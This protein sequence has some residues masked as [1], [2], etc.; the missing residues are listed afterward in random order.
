MTER[1]A[2]PPAI[3]PGF[4]APG[5]AISPITLLHEV[6]WGEMDALQHVNNTVYIKWFEDVRF[7]WFERVGFSACLARDNQFPILA[8]TNIN[9]LSPVTFPDH[10]YVSTRAVRI[11]RSSLDLDCRAW[12]CS[13]QRLCAE[14]TATIVMF[15]YA[16]QSSTPIPEPVRAAIRAL[17]AP[18]GG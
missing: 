2:D 18:P 14:G 15:D 1:P 7:H 13:R 11:G 9:F 10:V 8:N 17:D 3:P 6:S 5:E 12:S 16:T 4:A